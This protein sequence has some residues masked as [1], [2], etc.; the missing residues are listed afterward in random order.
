M[1]EHHTPDKPQKRK[2]LETDY[3]DT[4]PLINSKKIKEIVDDERVLNSKH[5]GEAHA[6]TSSIS[7]DSLHSSQQ[8]PDR[9]SD[10]LEQDEI[11]E[12][13]IFDM[14]AEEDTTAVDVSGTEET[15]PQ[16]EGGTSAPEMPLESK[17]TPFSQTSCIQ[18]KNSNALCWLDCILSA[19]VHLEALR[20]AVMT[21][22][23]SKE[24]SVFWQLFTKYNQASMLH[25]SQSDRVKGWWQYFV[26]RLT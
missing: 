7:P 24:E 14:A 26:R 21:D 19:L 4:P 1:Q 25:T 20:K 18:W 23:C 9:T 11:L 8:N 22:L 6:E 2:L 5:N 3:K 10:S 16:N 13:A 17:C 12:A 15:A